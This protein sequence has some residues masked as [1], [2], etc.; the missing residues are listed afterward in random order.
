MVCISTVYRFTMFM[1]FNSEF[2]GEEINF[3]F[4][5]GNVRSQV[6]FSEVFLLLHFSGCYLFNI[7]KIPSISR[8]Q[9]LCHVPFFV[10]TPEYLEY[11]LYQQTK[12]EL[13]QTR[14]TFVVTFVAL[15][16]WVVINYLNN[17]VLD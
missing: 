2:S 8:I 11:I 6:R 5:E 4:A 1:Y 10:L 3:N 16:V 17:V 7:I 15:G 13:D 12:Q 14:F 9:I